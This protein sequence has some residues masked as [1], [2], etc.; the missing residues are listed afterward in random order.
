ML[1]FFPDGSAVV[2]LSD[3][4]GLAGVVADG[5]GLPGLAVDGL[6]ESG[7]G[8][9]GFVSFAGDGSFGGGSSGGSGWHLLLSTT[10]PALQVLY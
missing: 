8:V 9:S 10:H 7:W 6:L 3:C 4:V 2:G 5:F 1:L